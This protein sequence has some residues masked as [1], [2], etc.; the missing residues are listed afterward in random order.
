MTT[1][2]ADGTS[3]PVGRAADL[4]EGRGAWVWGSMGWVLQPSGLGFGTLALIFSSWMTLRKSLKFFA[5]Q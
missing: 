1:L 4:S 2:T 3:P 5:L